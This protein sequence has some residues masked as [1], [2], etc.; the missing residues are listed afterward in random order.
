MKISDIVSV[1]RT[2]NDFLINL[3][4]LPHMVKAVMNAILESGLNLNPQ[5]DGHVIYIQ[6]PKVTTEHRQNLI[7]GVKQ[8]SVKVKND[9]KDRNFHKQFEQEDVSTLSKD[10]INNAQANLHHYI[11]RKCTIIDEITAQKC[12][13]LSSS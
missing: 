2:K 9:L 5:I 1:T 6:M 7:K 3:E 8:L 10:L 4:P 12:D 13:S 11:K